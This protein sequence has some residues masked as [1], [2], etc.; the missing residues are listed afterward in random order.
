[1][2]L[3]AAVFV[4]HVGLKMEGGR[5]WIGV[6]SFTLQPSEVAKLGLVIYLAS[7]LARR[8]DKV[9]TLSRGLF[10][11]ALVSAIFCAFVLFEPDFGTASLLAF[12]TGAMLFAAGARLEHLGAILLASLPGAYLEIFRSDYRRDRILAFLDPWKYPKHEG[13][14]IVQSLMALGSGGPIGVG[15][16]LSK[17]KFWLPEAYTD[18]A[19]AVVGEEFGF[20]GMCAIVLLFIVFAYRAV[21]IALR[22]E[23]AF[24]YFLVIGCMSI[25]VIQAFVSI[26]VVSASWP[27]TGVPLPFISYGGTSLVVSLVAAALIANVGRSRRTLPAA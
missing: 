11:V 21:R 5:R 19:G 23:D 25:I 4:P 9:R 10:P 24:G 14:Q 18:F 7:A 16:G 13:F 6:G 3:L 12:T 2:A 1:L 17:Q 8:G 15:P 26:G 22:T 27:V 20:I